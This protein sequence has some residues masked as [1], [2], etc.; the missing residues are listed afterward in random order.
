M[1]ITDVANHLPKKVNEIHIQP[2]SVL[3]LK[4]PGRKT[5][6]AKNINFM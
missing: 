4:K 1:G 6:R 5:A 3:Y 2:F